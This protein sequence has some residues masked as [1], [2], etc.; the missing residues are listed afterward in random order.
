MDGR[1]DPA[2]S[3]DRKSDAEKYVTTVE[4][5]ALAG[6]F[7]NR[8]D[9]TRPHRKSTSDHGGRG[10]PQ[11]RHGGRVPAGSGQGD[12]KTRKSRR[13]LKLPT[14]A[15]QALRAH[16]ARQAAER[17]AAGRRGSPIW[18][19]AARTGGRWTAGRYGRSSR[20]SPG[21]PGSAR[22]GRPAAYGTRLCPSSARTM[23]A[24]RTSATYLGTAAASRP[25]R[26]FIRH[27]I[28]P[29]LTY[30]AT[31]VNRIPEGER[32]RPGC[33]APGEPLAPQLAPELTNEKYI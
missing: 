9:R 5:E 4:A 33:P 22:H 28:R 3:F 18:C 2:R 32:Q 30:S 10:R 19:S 13:V 12:T 26:R 1:E 6:V 21:T 23:S 15:A 24:W 27:E 17:L 20:R 29:T 8:S 7:V 14:K 16:R 11:G 25:P 31:A